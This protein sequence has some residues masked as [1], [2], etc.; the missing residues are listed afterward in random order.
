MHSQSYNFIFLAFWCVFN[1]NQLTV[2]QWSP[3]LPHSKK[4]DS[5]RGEGLSMWSL[6]VWPMLAVS[7]FDQKHWL[8][9]GIGP[10]A[11]YCGHTVIWQ[12]FFSSFQHVTGSFFTLTVSNQWHQISVLILCHCFGV[13]GRRLKGGAKESVISI[14]FVYNNCSVVWF[15]L[16]SYFIVS[17]LA[18]F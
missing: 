14:Q 5:W 10:Q 9:P 2:A 6:H 13:K 15:V 7:T 3:P 17:M 12:I 11:L 1:D 8:R 16:P 18:F 4:T